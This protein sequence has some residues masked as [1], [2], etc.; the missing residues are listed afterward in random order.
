LYLLAFETLMHDA[1]I[2]VFIGQVARSVARIRTILMDE[3]AGAVSGAA[4]GGDRVLLG[5]VLPV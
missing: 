2:A 5:L 1:S 4:P 3:P